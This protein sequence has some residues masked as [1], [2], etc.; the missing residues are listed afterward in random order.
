MM[1]RELLTANLFLREPK[2]AKTS[3]WEE[4]F[5]SAK[6]SAHLPP[7]D[8]DRLRSSFAHFQAMSKFQPPLFPGATSTD[9]P[10]LAL[11]FS[12]PGG[13]QNLQKLSQGQNHKGES[14][15][16][17]DD[18]HSVLVVDDDEI[19]NDSKDN[20]SNKSN[21]N[22]NTMDS[23]D[24]K[25]DAEESKPAHRPAHLQGHTSPEARSKLCPDT[26]D[27]P[28]SVDK[29]AAKTSSSDIKKKIWSPRDS[30]SPP[31][32]KHRKLHAEHRPALRQDHDCRSQMELDLGRISAN[33]T[34]LQS[35]QLVTNVSENDRGRRYVCT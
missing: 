27:K 5:D 6:L 22:V 20:R 10:L 19:D 15:K 34:G 28:K 12:M 8:Y 4:T 23:R 21:S 1:A 33:H 11:D 2:F 32:H 7:Q 14:H 30:P 18:K 35:S 9:H 31:L 29:E 16:T 13:Q 3:G 17:G 25:K 26:R 24:D